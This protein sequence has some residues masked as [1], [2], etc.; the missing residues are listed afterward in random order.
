MMD[1]KT[2]L[3]HLPCILFEPDE[4]TEVQRRKS[5]TLGRTA[6]AMAE[7]WRPGPPGPG[8]EQVAL[9]PLH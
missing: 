7:R 8:V 6:S 3:D 4:D 5:F 2:L 1:G 9:A